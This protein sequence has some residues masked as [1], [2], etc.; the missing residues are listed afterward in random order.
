LIQLFSMTSM[1][2]CFMGD[3]QW[4]LVLWV[5]LVLSQ[6]LD[7]TIWSH[8]ILAPTEQFYV[9]IKNFAKA[10]NYGAW[11]LKNTP[12]SRSSPSNVIVNLDV[13]LCSSIFPIHVHF[14]WNNHYFLN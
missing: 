8:P 11:K 14:M 5:K 12:K 1:V 2:A 3:S 4:E 6:L 13:F 7:Q 9:K 10:N